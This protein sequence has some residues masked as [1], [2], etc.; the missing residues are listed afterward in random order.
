MARR[1]ALAVVR[2]ETRRPPLSLPRL[3]APSLRALAVAGALAGAAML[4]Y[5]AARETALFAVRAVEISGASGQTARDVRRE[6]EPLV[7]SSLV[8]LDAEALER[9]LERLPT[10]RVARVDRAFPHA[11]AVVVREEQAV[12]VLRDATHARVVSESGRV[13]QLVRPRALARL[14]RI[15]MAGVAALAA[16]E[17]VSDG[18]VR[19]ALR[20][21]SAVPTRFPARLVAARAKDGAVTLV[22]AGGRELHL[23][24]PHAV[25]TKLEAAAA[26]LSSL[27]LSER[28]RVAY[29]DVSVPN[30]PVARIDPQVESQG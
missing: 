3:R 18:R 24:P 5:A 10:V 4:A 30:R 28:R 14:P 25:Q 2:T 19:L 6:L 16:G 1:P 29:V 27:S 11:L 23:G 7:G 9:R 13:I 26:V 22:L 21:L 17:R 20:V 12:A 8:A 15:W